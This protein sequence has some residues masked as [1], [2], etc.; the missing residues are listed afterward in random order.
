VH[1]L[2]LV[3][4]DQATNV[5]MDSETVCHTGGSWL[6]RRNSEKDIHTTLADLKA[7][8]EGADQRH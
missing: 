8:I 1:T 6:I 5:T 4:G 2:I 7:K 3:P